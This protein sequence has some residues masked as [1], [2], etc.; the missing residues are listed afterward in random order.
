MLSASLNK[1]FLSLSVHCVL[2]CTFTVL[3][4][5]TLLS[6]S[7]LAALAVDDDVDLTANIEGKTC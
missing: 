3:M 1:T 7:K 5:Q 2:E 4:F 6:L